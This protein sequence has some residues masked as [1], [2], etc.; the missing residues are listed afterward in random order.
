MRG[1]TS[2]TAFC[3]RFRIVLPQVSIPSANPCPNFWGKVTVQS[4][5]IYA[6]GLSSSAC[7]V[8]PS[9][10]ASIGMAPP[11]A[12]ISNTFGR[13]A[14]AASMSASVTFCLSLGQL[15]SFT[16]TGQLPSLTASASSDVSREACAARICFCA[17]FMTFGLPGY[18]HN[19]VTNFAAFARPRDCFLSSGPFPGTNCEAG[20]SAP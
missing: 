6:T 8:H 11:P 5:I 4:P 16:Q 17:F 2:D 14:F 10:A 9:L 20:T 1:I 15:N 13:G 7:D 12:N 18:L 3:V 19:S